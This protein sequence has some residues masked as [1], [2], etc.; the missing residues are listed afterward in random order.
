MR[1]SGYAEG[2]NLAVEFLNPASLAEYPERMKELVQRHVDIIVA[3]GP[4][5]ALKSAMAGNK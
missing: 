2:Q 3:P 5:L 1:E 4:E